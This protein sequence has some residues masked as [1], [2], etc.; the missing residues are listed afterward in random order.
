MLKIKVEACRYSCVNFRC[1]KC[2]SYDI[3]Y[4]NMPDTCWNCG[5]KYQF[6]LATLIKNKNER[7]FFHFNKG[8][9]SDYYHD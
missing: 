1:P 6:D 9:T 5:S 2:K 3:V 4:I 8:E 7:I